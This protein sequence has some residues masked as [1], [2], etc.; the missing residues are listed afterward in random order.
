L[1]IPKKNKLKTLG[2]EQTRNIVLVLTFLLA[3]ANFF[4]TCEQEEEIKDITY[5]VNSLQFQPRL[6]LVGIPEI[7]K[8]TLDTFKLEY[9]QD[10]IQLKFDSII[11]NSKIKVTNLSDNALAS[12]VLLL[13][14]DTIPNV[15]DYFIGKKILDS[16]YYNYREHDILDKRDILPNDTTVLTTT[17]NVKHISNRY[18]LNYIIL[19]KNELGNFYHTHILVPYSFKPL[20]FR[21]EI[22]STFEQYKD[23]IYSFIYSSIVNNKMMAIGT[24]VSFYEIYNKDETE[25]VKNHL[26]RLI[27]E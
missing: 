7:T 20:A 22:L 13:Y 11:V 18:I 25:L 4:R 17:I 8:V 15:K 12:F 27:P 23:S 19:Y 9:D 1:G 10:K 21:T 14:T 2:W 16:V 3:I 6:K 5:N 26:K 24:P